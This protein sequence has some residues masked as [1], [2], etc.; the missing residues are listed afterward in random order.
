MALAR[1]ISHPP[2][3]ARLAPDSRKGLQ[4][5]LR[6][7]DGGA[8]SSLRSLRAASVR[9]V[10]N[11]R[12]ACGRPAGGLRGA[13]AA[14]GLCDVMGR[15]PARPAGGLP[16]TRRSK[17]PP[18]PGRP[19]FLGPPGTGGQSFRGTTPASLQP[20]GGSLGFV[21]SDQSTK[22]AGPALATYGGQPGRK[23]ADNRR[24]AYASMQMLRPGK[25]YLPGVSACFGVSLQRPV[26]EP[27]PCA[28]VLRCGRGR[29]RFRLC[30]SG[31]SS[32]RPRRRFAPATGSL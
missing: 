11:L 13:C 20:R 25:A 1:S 19:R 16:S 21:P 8:C 32:A 24:L 5:R 17:K 28:F 18:A 26:A 15:R 2:P 14:S 7:A 6:C 3:R 10:R 30:G 12:A 9:L 29:L 23:Q 31:A 27:R 4:A 22:Q